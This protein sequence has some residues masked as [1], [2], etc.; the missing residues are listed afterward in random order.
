LCLL[1]PKSSN[2]YF[3]FVFLKAHLC[4]LLQTSS[5]WITMVNTE[6]KLIYMSK[7]SGNRIDMLW[8]KYN[9]FDMIADF[10][11]KS[12]RSLAHICIY[13]Y[14]IVLSFIYHLHYI[15]IM[16][17]FSLSL[18]VHRI[19]LSRAVNITFSLKWYFLQI[20]C[21]DI[22]YDDFWACKMKMKYLIY[23][24]IWSPNFHSFLISYHIV[25]SLSLFHSLDIC[26]CKNSFAFF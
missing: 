9:I 1:L 4:A 24:Q 7:Y 15:L 11:L 3:F 12:V 8:K 19:T 16:L 18:S 21:W 6:R 17:F 10:W 25:V 20:E 23:M 26:L 5:L 14:L 2:W 13:A 22:N